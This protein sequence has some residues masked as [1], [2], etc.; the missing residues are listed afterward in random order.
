MVFMKANILIVYFTNNPK[1]NPACEVLS[2]NRVGTNYT[3][4][5]IFFLQ[6]ARCKFRNF[7]ENF[8][9]AKS[10]K[11]HIFGVEVRDKGLIYLNK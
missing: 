8:I 7:R 5:W 11:T 6:F 9:F 10:V 2:K 4:S 3:R 1:T